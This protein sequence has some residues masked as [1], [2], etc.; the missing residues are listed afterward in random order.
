MGDIHFMYKMC[1]IINR[2]MI[3]ISYKWILY[4][5]ILLYCVY[6]YLYVYH[7][8]QFAYRGSSYHVWVSP[9]LIMINNVRFNFQILFWLFLHLCSS[10]ILDWAQQWTAPTVF[11]ED[12]IL[13]PN[14]HCQLRDLWQ[15]ISSGSVIFWPLKTLHRETT[16]RQNIPKFK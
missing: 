1:I 12:Q 11:P 9:Q 16:C 13:V 7:I 6:Y 15:S 5:I 2:E 3:L 8:Y 4:I 14:N 10:K